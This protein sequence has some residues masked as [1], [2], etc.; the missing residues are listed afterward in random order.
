MKILFLNPNW[1]SIPP[2]NF[3]GCRRPHHPLE[4]L[5]PA[6]ILSEDHDVLV[7]DAF[8]ERLSDRD[9]KERLASFNPEV[10]VMTTAPSY[11]FWRCC[12]LDISLTL[13]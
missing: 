7:I 12:P 2:R 5:Y 3:L 8:L 6:T 10:V 13:S 11:L 4:L 1:S 9:L